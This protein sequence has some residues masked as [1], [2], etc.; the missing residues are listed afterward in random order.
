MTSGRT[1]QNKLV[2]SSPGTG[3]PPD[4]SPRCGS[5]GVRP[6][7]LAGELVGVTARPFKTRI[8]VAAL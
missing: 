4:R 8:P 1:R 6:H 5:G 3:S 7:W 2:H